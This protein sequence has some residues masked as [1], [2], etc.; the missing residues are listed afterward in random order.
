MKS[1]FLNTLVPNEPVTAQFLVLSKEIRQKRTGEPY[2][3]LH[4]ADRT[5]EIEARMWDNVVEVMHTFERD[6][7]VK[8]K[9]LPQLHNNRSQ[10]LI[11][12]LRRL[13]DHEVEFSDYFPCSERD[14][15]EMF[16][17]L[18]GIIAGIGNLH[19]RSLLELIFSDPKFCELYKIAPAAKTIHHACRGGLLEHVLSLCS[20]G[21]LVGNHYRKVDV[22]LLITGVILHDVGKIEELSYDRSFGYSSDG[23]LLGHIVLGLRFIA[24]KL[25][26][27]P[28]FPP[29]LRVLVEHMVISHHGELEFGSPKV[30]L[31]PEALLLHH[32]D[33]LDSKMNA[34]R[35]VLD[36]D[37]LTETEFTAWVPSLERVLLHTDRYLKGQQNPERERTASQLPPPP[38]PPPAEPPPQGAVTPH[39]ETEPR[40]REAVARDLPSTTEKPT[41]SPQPGAPDRPP[42]AHPPLPERKPEPRQPTNTL[43]AEKL[44]AVLGD[45]K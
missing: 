2:L 9:G 1:P 43:F 37:R 18:S 45:R 20:L 4:L 30:P 11:H 7:F 8:V 29:K 22:D 38:A 21:K 12:R 14:P 25:E 40:P 31:F 39:I 35:T 24:N 13:Q 42:Q 19:L 32:L 33:N 28:D 34:M 15:G 41:S 23:Q 3:S 17:E 5:G 16:A 36:H 27:L 44:Q 6:D 26:R 10:F